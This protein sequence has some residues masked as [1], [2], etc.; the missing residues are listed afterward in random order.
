MSNA[1]EIATRLGMPRRLVS[2][3][4]RNLSRKARALRAALEGAAGVKRQAEAARFAAES[5][6][7]DADRA[8][9]QAAD[10]RDALEQQKSDFQKWVQ[11]VV[12]LQA[13]DP[14]RVRN[15]DR[16]GR[17]VRMRID[18][19]RAEVDVGSFSVE[20]PLGDIL[21]PETPPPPPR[22]PR[23]PAAK[24]APRKPARPRRPA[25]PARDSRVESRQRKPRRR[26]EAKARPKRQYAPL[27]EAEIKALQFGDGVVVKRLHRQG[28]IVRVELEKRFAI[29]SVGAF[30]VEVPFDGLA[31]SELSRK[32]PADIPPSKSAEP[33][34]FGGKRPPDAK[35]EQRAP[36][37]AEPPVPEA[38]AAPDAKTE[39]PA[40]KPTEPPAPEPETAPDTT[41]EQ[42]GLRPQ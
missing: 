15:F 28:R 30:E 27:T 5:A 37:P 25:Q 9:N 3:A 34:A 42:P 22:P 32:P 31:V 16:D 12:H 6:R 33:S 10:A 36:R 29:V 39:Q 4:K 38:E 21:P 19:H 35:E 41:S 40:A 8:Q 14:V 2:A 17:V 1:L 23:A 18:Q 11:Q 13:G 26:D 7:L 20:V 24:P